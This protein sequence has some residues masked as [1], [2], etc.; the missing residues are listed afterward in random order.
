ML[1]YL[2]QM[3][4][5]M[6]TRPIVQKQVRLIMQTFHTR[7]TPSWPKQ[8]GYSFFRPAA[9]VFANL[10][11][12]IP[13]SLTRITMYNIIIYFMTHLSRNGGAFWTFHL[14]TY[15]AFLTMQGFFRT[16]GLLATNF[17]VA[18]RVAT[19]FLPNII[20]YTGYMIPV[21]QMKRFL[22]WIVS[23]FSTLRVIIHH[24]LIWCSITS[25]LYLIVSRW[26]H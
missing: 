9:I 2:F 23:V 25:T 17:D 6:V 26:S 3:P 7:L 18:F 13:F 15:L 12:D 19:I 22:F 24:D 14:T 5:Q 16:F 11:S 4:N 20:Q 10:F 8:I 21:A 1:T